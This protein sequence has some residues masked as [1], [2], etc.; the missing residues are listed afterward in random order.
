[1]F[2]TVRELNQH[3]IDVWW[4]CDTSL[5]D[6]GPT[7]TAQVQTQNEKGLLQFLDQV[8]HML[9]NP[10]RSREEAQA[11]QVR[12]GTT[13]RGLAEEALGFTTG[14]LDRLPS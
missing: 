9:S 7:Y 4:D 14:Q 8:E 10:P 1:M 5:P 3:F 6:L 13:F 2:T 11:I 12:L